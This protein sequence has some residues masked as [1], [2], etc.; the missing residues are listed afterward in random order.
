MLCPVKT[1]LYRPLKRGKKNTKMNISM[2]GIVQ[3]R[4]ALDSLPSKE[5]AGIPK[6]NSEVV[7]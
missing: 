1:F 6:K 2:H 7:E 4:G 3:A 5:V